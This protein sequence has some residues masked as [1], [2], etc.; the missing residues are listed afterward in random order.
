[1]K[2]LKEFC[3][4]FS[5]LKL[6][7]NFFDFEIDK[8]FFDIFNYSRYSSCNISLNLEFRKENLL[9]DLRFSYSGYCEVICDRCLDLVK[10][11]IINKFNCLIKFFHQEQE[12]IKEDIIYLHKESYEYNIGQL[13]Y[14]YFI[15][16][17]PKRVIHEK[18]QCNNKQIKLMRKYSQ[19]PIRTE[20]DPRWNILKELKNEN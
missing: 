17:F 16:N 20:E 12:I 4:P 9:M 13:F 19:K 3:I 11:P 6:G 7:P 18:N 14:E 1:M 15:V 2:E 8:S 10:V 5:S